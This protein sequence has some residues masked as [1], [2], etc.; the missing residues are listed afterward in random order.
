MGRTIGS[1]DF[2]YDHLDSW[3]KL[4]DGVR[5]VE[6]PGVA[7]NSRDEVYALTRNTD[8]P[9]MVFDR[10]GKFLHSFGKDVFSNRTHGADVRAGRP[11][12]SAPTTERTLSRSGRPR[13]SS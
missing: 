4:P 13:A 12:Y 11:L 1:G 9:V 2:K 6:T 7:V 10:G 3:Q 5:M 8:H